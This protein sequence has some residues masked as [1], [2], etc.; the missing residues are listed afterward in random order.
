MSVS[1]RE[2][3]L[4]R[5]RQQHPHQL[6]SSLESAISDSEDE[7]P[8]PI[9]KLAVTPPEPVHPPVFSVNHATLSNTN[10]NSLLYRR[11]SSVSSGSDVASSK[12]KLS[13]TS[14]ASDSST[15]SPSQVGATGS[16]FQ[17]RISFDTIS[18]TPSA[19]QPASSFKFARPSFSSASSMKPVVDSG[20]CFSVSSKHVE[21]STTY[22]SRSFLCSM[23]SVHN[24]KPALLWLVQNVMENGD[25]LVCLK[26]VHDSSFEPVHYQHEAED[27]LSEVVK[28]LDTSLKIKVVVEVALGSIKTV[29]RKTMLL[30]QPA[31]VVV[32]TTAKTYSN[33]MRYMT[34]K[35]LSNYLLN[36]SPVPVIVILPELLEK[37]PVVPDSLKGRKSSSA[38]EDMEP[39]LSTTSSPTQHPLHTFNYLTNLINRPSNESDAVEVDTGPAFNYKSLFQKDSASNTSN[40]ECDPLD[41]PAAKYPS[42]TISTESSTKPLVIDDE[43]KENEKQ[44]Q[45]Y[46][47]NAATTTKSNNFLHTS[48]SAGSAASKEKRPSW[49][50]RFIPK[51]LR[52]LSAS[53]S[54]YTATK[55]VPGTAS[56]PKP[57]S[58]SRSP[59]GGS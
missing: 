20:A 35:T 39:A 31:L 2:P 15:K 17:K 46:T 13:T 45:A 51:G 38:S 32:G 19:P 34:R 48:I 57:S 42:I 11:L 56:P 53:A 7:Q 30:Y 33:V 9:P 5:L 8:T 24:S 3:N 10:S 37:S 50:S 14:T 4:A 41:S 6:H 52:R 43:V 36:H 22:W 55:S 44:P 59:F 49:S 28:A 25:E 21:H 58:R 16:P 47:G 54:S 18:Q 29:V 27:L 26:V 40:A 12:R 23:S 1:F